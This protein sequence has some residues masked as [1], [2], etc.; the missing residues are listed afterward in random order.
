MTQGDLTG[1]IVAKGADKYG[2]WVYTK[3]AAK[4][5]TVITVLTAYQPCKILKK[6]GITTYHQQVVMLQQDGRQL[7]PREAFII[8]LTKWLEEGKK[9]GKLFIVGGDF[10]K[11]LKIGSKL[12]EL[13]TNNKVPLVDSL[14]S[15]E[16][17]NKS[18]SL[19][20]HTIIDYVFVSP[21]L[22]PDIWK[23]GYNQFDQLLVTD[24][25]GMFIDFDT[26]MLF[27]NGD[28]KLANKKMRYIRAKDPYMVK[29]YINYMYEYLEN[30]IFWQLHSQLISKKQL[31]VELAER[32]DKIL[33]NASLVAESKCKFRKKTGGLS[34]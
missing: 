12:L 11:A 14:A 24:H 3:F 13:C 10:N 25:R 34:H 16:R 22:L 23:Q 26:E 8:D 6:Q 33:T 2:R 32:V 31:D 30:Q 17:E 18:S 4:N 5:N 9:K 20:G 28:L 7:T 19:S 29:E 21:E 1:R 27:G 15:K